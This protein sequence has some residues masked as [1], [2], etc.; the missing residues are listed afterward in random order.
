[1]TRT[2]PSWPGPI[3]PR[4]TFAAPCPCG[5]EA[6]WEQSGNGPA[7]VRILCSCAAR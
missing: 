4:A 6:V 5:A 7:A 1:M 3:E 2:F